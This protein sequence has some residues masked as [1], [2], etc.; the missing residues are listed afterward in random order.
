MNLALGT[1]PVD[2]TPLAT[3]NIDNKYDLQYC[4]SC[5]RDYYEI[6]PEDK[7]IVYSDLESLSENNANPILLCGLDPKHEVRTKEPKSKSVDD[8]DYLIKKFGSHVR[9]TSRTELPS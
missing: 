2:K 3:R 1:C 4:P 6:K 8:N 7:K 5:H 9:I